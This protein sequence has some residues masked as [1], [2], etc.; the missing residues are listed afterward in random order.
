MRRASNNDGE[1]ELRAMHRPGVMTPH[2]LLACG[3]VIL[4][5]SVGT[6]QA[7]GLFL[8]PIN[9]ELHIGRAEFGFAIALQNLLWGLLQP[10][11]GMIADKHGAGRVLAAGAALYA[12]G[13]VL[14]ALS[15]S[16]IMLDWS[17][18]VL[19]G[20]G[21]S[22]CSFG[23]VMG[24]VGRAFEPR[25]R[26][27]ALGIVGAG[28]SFGQFAML[29]FG[30]A[31]ISA[32]GWK[33]ALFILAGTFVIVAVLAPAL[34][35]RPRVASSLEAPN[36]RAALDRVMVDR[37]FWFL[38]FSFAVC[39]FQTVFLMIHLPVYILDHGLPASVGVTALAIVGLCNTVGSYFCGVLGSRF[40]KKRILAGIYLLRAAAIGAYVLLPVTALSTYALAAIIGVT[41]LGTVP[42]TNA[43]VADMFGVRFLSTLFGI[44][45]LG[46]QI[47]SFFGAWY[48]GYV[49]DTTGSYA[50]VWTLCVATSLL[51]AILCWPIDDRQRHGT[52]A[53]STADA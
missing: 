4:M 6:R 53:A 26:S 48:G 36:V 23:V 49:F 8:P 2:L 47:G 40:R 44:A 32:A 30:A 46:H 15:Q 19:I 17:A 34:A 45:F 1:R 35:G 3:C 42:L 39:G 22:A 10:F 9:A 28:G 18:G 51:A 43:L 12:S 24:V 37:G 7:F 52:G 38:T 21:L 5:L 11:T 50:I 31:L 27:W 13:L 16:P 29:P 14:M 25:R 41:W 33:G 20:L